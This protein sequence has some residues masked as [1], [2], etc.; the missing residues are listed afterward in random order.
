MYSRLNAEGGDH[1]GINQPKR[2]YS[3]YLIWFKSDQRPSSFFV[4]KSFFFK[5][6]LK[7]LDFG[8]KGLLKRNPFFGYIKSVGGWQCCEYKLD[9]R[10]VLHACI[11]TQR[12]TMK[13]TQEY[14]F[15][16]LK[17]AGAVL[18]ENRSIFCFCGV[19]TCRKVRFL[20]ASFEME[21]FL[22]TS[23]VW[24]YVRDGFSWKVF[25]FVTNL[26]SLVSYTR[27]EFLHGRR[28]GLIIMIRTK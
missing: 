21:L 8:L 13:L 24:T 23:H 4:W 18:T 28:Q 11:R 19:C 26:F 14:D 27:W 3:V 2:N 15:P 1:L 22:V 20:F 6:K 7:Q 12:K 17:I 25:H 9:Y 10:A 16:E 5:I